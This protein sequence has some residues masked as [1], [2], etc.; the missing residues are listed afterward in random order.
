MTAVPRRL[1]ASL[2]L[3]AALLGGAVPSASAAAAAAA[4]ATTPTLSA[5]DQAVV[6]QVEEYLN[7]IHTMQSKFVQ[8]AP[9][10]R[11]TTGTFSLSRPG[12]MRLEYDKP[13][14][15]FV[16]ADGTF[17][18]YWD[19]EMRQQSSAPLG[20]TLADFILRKT[21]RL[22]GDVIVTGVYTTPGVV[23]VS[24]VEFE[25]FRQG[26]P[27]PGVRGPALPTAQMAGAGRAGPDDRG[28]VAEPAHRRD[29][30]QGHV[31]FQGTPEGIRFRAGQLTLRPGFS[32]GP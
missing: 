18:F 27:D 32:P 11:Q 21:I 26:H 9:D 7:G 20:S 5:P 16:V 31:L 1:L 25:G 3:S 30:R 10:G 14:K 24:L 19:G 22:A 12:K 17:I 4:A 15:D 13:I 28:G 6:A 2:F 8:V 29:V 23:E